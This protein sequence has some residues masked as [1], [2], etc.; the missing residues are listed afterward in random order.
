MRKAVILQS[1]YLPW[2]GVFELIYRADVF[3]FLEDVQYTER[4]WRNRNKVITSKGESWIT[5]PVRKNRNQ[6]ICETKLDTNRNWQKVH[7]KTFQVNYAKAPYYNQFKWILEDI[8]INNQWEKL[9]DLNIYSTKLI[10]ETLGIKTKFINTFDLNCKGKK[11]DK[12]I[13]IC[14]KLD[15]DYYISGPAAKAY[16]DPYKF[17]K[18]AIKLEY[19]EYNYPAYKQLYE[20]FNHYVTILDLIF[21]CGPDAPYYIWGWKEHI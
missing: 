17:D 13:D 19:I 12:L 1:N 18:N 21:N 7:Y 20:P 8:Y 2:K 9:S 15:C 4:D 3:A 14:K 6:L 11:D 16:I 10:A 5:V